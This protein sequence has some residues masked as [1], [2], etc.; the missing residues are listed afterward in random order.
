ME[1]DAW[2]SI[3]AGLC[4]ESGYIRLGDY[5]KDR[6]EEPESTV[7]DKIVKARVFRR[8]VMNDTDAPVSGN[9]L[10][11]LSKIKGA[12][13]E[14]T[15]ELRPAAYEEAAQVA[16]ETRMLEKTIRYTVTLLG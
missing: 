6:W 10:I 13:E 7:N 16:E 11:E 15:D 9:A 4:K 1:A 14:E 3:K 8:L 5:L 12:T 2:E